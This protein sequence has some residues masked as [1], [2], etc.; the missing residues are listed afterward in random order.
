M[1]M[2]RTGVI[3][4][5][6][7][8][9]EY[10]D[11]TVEDVY[12]G[13]SSPYSASART[14]AGEFSL[15]SIQQ[16]LGGF[17]SRADDREATSNPD[18]LPSASTLNM[19]FVRRYEESAAH[20]DAK[21]KVRTKIAVAGYIAAV[22]VLVLAVSL[23]AVAVSGTFTDMTAANAVYSQTA[24][25]LEELRGQLSQEDYE[26]LALR[27]A[28]LGYVDASADNSNTYT[29]IETRPAQNFNVETNWFDQLCDWFSGVFGG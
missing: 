19:S 5:R 27:A 17:D 15:Q 10:R 28:E 26:A 11:D 13:I 6:N 9:S 29:Q 7:P 12:S 3:T 23:C 20:S 4:R 25:Q 14:D 22:L 18:L 16:K 1:D 21:V 8:D 2:T 24:A